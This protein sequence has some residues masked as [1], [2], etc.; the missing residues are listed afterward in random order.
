MKPFSVYILLALIFVN[1]INAQTTD[2]SK[3]SH[4]K[5]ILENEY[6]RLLDGKV[7]VND[8]TLAHTHSSNSVVVFL[9]KSKFGIQNIGGKPVI[10]D[11]S[12]GD[13]IYRSFGDKPVNHIVWNQSAPMLHFLVVDLMK[14]KLSKDSCAMIS[15]GGM[16]V[17]LRKKEARVYRLEI[18][19]GQHVNVPNSNCAYLLVALSG[20]SKVGT[21]GNMKSLS[22]DGF[23]FFPPKSEIVISNADSKGSSFIL[24]E[25]K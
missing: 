21:K 2:A 22:P 7:S 5:V 3:E 25:L 13:V 16:N 9:S 23:V 12:P 4:H 11:V 10:T 14:K 19:N 15:L 18:T 17:Q 1:K 24:V 6:I 20:N 8:T